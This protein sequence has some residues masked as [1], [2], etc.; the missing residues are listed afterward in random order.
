MSHL[1]PKILSNQIWV[2][3]YF[4]QPLTYLKFTIFIF[5]YLCNSLKSQATKEAF[6]HTNWSCELKVM[7]LFF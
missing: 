3:G 7:A 5:N 1:T 2:A 6:I 4:G